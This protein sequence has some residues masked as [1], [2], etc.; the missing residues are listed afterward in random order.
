MRVAAL[1]LV[2]LGLGATRTGQAQDSTSRGWRGERLVG[3][4]RVALDATYIKLGPEYNDVPA[5]WSFLGSAAAIPFVSDHWQVGVLPSWQLTIA[6]GSHFYS[7][8]IG[9]MAN[10]VFGDGNV[11]RPYIGAEWEEHGISSNK[12]YGAYGVQAGWVH[13]LSP[14]LALR[15]ELRYRRSLTPR[16]T[17]ASDIYVTF[18]PYLFGRVPGASHVL[19][20]LGVFDASFLADLIFSPGH[21]GVL[22][23]NAAP[24]IT[25]W[26]QLGGEADYNF[27]FD[28]SDGDHYVEGFA[29]GY[30]PV[31]AR[32]LPFGDV[33]AATQNASRQGGWV[34]SH[35][36]RAGLR[37]NL[38]AGVA[39]DVALQWRDYS[40]FTQTLPQLDVSVGER[41]RVP[42]VRTVRVTL[43]TQFRAARRR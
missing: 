14:S 32:M 23:A 2:A 41:K 35:G 26:L 22:N 13:F 3:S 34:G 27:Y 1:V 17:E 12:A 10:Y 4:T 7:G 19:P 43:T 31:S 30:L 18:D 38:A 37:T 33:F 16:P 11:S 40:L 24:F 6:R 8:A 39:L 20:S 42:E 25:R 21:T 29:R 36:G 5:Q 15:T 28:E 9:A